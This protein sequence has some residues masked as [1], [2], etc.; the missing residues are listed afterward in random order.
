MALKVVPA[1]DER[2]D[3]HTRRKPARYICETCLKELG[4]EAGP[5]T[6]A[7]RGPVR[8]FRRALR[9][10]PFGQARRAMRRSRWGARPKLLIGAGLTLLIAAVVVVTLLGGG[11]DEN[12]APSEADV[13][14]ALDLLPNPAGSGW[15]TSDGACVVASIDL[16]QQ[17]PPGGEGAELSVEAANEDGTV[18]A[19]VVQNDYTISQDE[20][21][22]QVETALRN[23]F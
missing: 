19:V 1:D 17:Q 13:V 22:A 4:L 18:A 8:R 10:G 9:R 12:G 7:T 5:A 11:E 14:N 15:I 2:C 3:I 21:V 6:T 23:E 16:G 20:C